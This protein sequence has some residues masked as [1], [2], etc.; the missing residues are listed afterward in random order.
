MNHV[1]NHCIILHCIFRHK[2]LFYG[3]F[4][5]QNVVQEKCRNDAMLLITGM[6]NSMI[7]QEESIYTNN[8]I[9][10]YTS[11]K[12][13]IDLNGS[14][15]CFRC[16]FAIRFW[17]YLRINVNF[18]EPCVVMVEEFDNK[19]VFFVFVLCLVGFYSPATRYRWYRADEYVCSECVMCECPVWWSLTTPHSRAVGEFYPPPIPLG[20]DNKVIHTCS[21]LSN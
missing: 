2:A 16:A 9:I 12:M 1:H 6:H 10:L 14:V 19:V 5:I 15:G 17:F 18:Q 13:K 7:I 3:L 21:T 11:R 8:K 4:G 20:V